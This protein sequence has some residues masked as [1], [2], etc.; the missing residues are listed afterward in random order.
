MR[1]T[2]LSL[3]SPVSGL[4]F[5]FAFNFVFVFVFI[6]IFIFT[7]I[8]KPG[9]A[10]A[11]AATQKTQA[12]PAKA[13][14]AKTGAAKTETSK[15]KQTE[16]TSVGPATAGA[17]VIATI[18]GVCSAGATPCETRITRGEF[19]RLLNTVNPQ[20]PPTA[21][22]QVAALYVQL[23]ALAQEAQKQGVDKDPA[24]QERARL[25]HLR[26]LSEVISTRLKEG[27]KPS[28]QEIETFYAE[29]R[30]RLE[31]VHLFAVIVPKAAAAS[32]ELAQKMQTRA[33]AG[34]DL[35][36]L[37]VEA[38][39]QAKSEGAPPN[40]DLGWRGRGRLGPFESEV[41][42]LKGGG[43][44]PVLEDAQN[45]Y[46]FKV[47]AKRMVPLATAKD[48][49]VTALLNQRYDAKVGHLLSNV[50]A[51][52]DAKYFGPPEA[53]PP[54]PGAEAQPKPTTQP[55]PPPAAEKP[56]Q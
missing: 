9:F 13:A 35:A 10:A 51:D 30:D 19:D 43:V 23:L 27:L 53:A 22:R 28:D 47:E 41:L 37:Q 42:Q 38:S 40:T 24:F 52:L 29:N 45:Y 5:V 6:F 49:I 33:A 21:R 15:P 4:P 32:K 31:E 50:K 3:V 44:S 12:N 16:K 11:Q 20:L 18:H 2:S 46:V 54:K 55:P 36:K 17:E 25:E 1:K 7:F 39:T 14:P 56:K 34:E 8:F 26:L 48:E